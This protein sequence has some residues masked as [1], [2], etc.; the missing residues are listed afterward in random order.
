MRGP[1]ER[2]RDPPGEP[3]VAGAAAQ[4]RNRPRH[5]ARTS[6]SST[7]TIGSGT[8][9]WNDSPRMPTRTARTSSSGRWS[10]W[11]AASRRRSSGAPCR[12][13]RSASTASRTARRPTRCSGARS[14]IGSGFASRRARGASKTTCSSPAAYLR[15]DVVSVYAETDCY[16]H[17]SRDDGRNAGF[18][19]YDPVPYYAVVEEVI[20]LVEDHLPAGA[21]RERYLSRW[22]RNELIGRLRSPIVRD[23]PTARRQV[24]YD[25]V[26]RIVRQR[27]AP[28]ALRATTATVAVGAAIARHAPMSEF[29]RADDA[30][31]RIDVRAW[32]DDGGIGLELMDAGRTLTPATTLAAVLRAHALAVDRRAC[33]RRPRRAGGGARR[34]RPYHPDLRR[35]ADRVHG[36]RSRLPRAGRNRARGRPHPG[37]VGARATGDDGDRGTPTRRGRVWGGGPPTPGRAA[38]QGLRRCGSCRRACGGC[39]AVGPVPAEPISPRGRGPLRRWARRRRASPCG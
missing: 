22:L 14:S 18:R 17:T 29:Y 13:R 16:F 21:A 7:R 2:P 34:S 10:A 5:A 6:S 28:T 9:R 35:T 19:S 3:R 38:P 26:S 4:R 30:L 36:R 20:D 15:A 32:E 37:G 31:H 8:R 11:I 25:E 23:L 12:A 24:F 27:Y 39:S 1:R 33:A